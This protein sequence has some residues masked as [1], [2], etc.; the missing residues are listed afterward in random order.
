MRSAQFWLMSTNCV[1][2]GVKCI[3]LLVFSRQSSIGVP[4]PP[5]G[6]FRRCFITDQSCCL[7]SPLYHYLPS[8]CFS[9]S[10][11]PETVL[12]PENGK[13][14]KDQSVPIISDSPLN[15]VITLFQYSII[16]GCCK[17]LV[18]VCWQQITQEEGEVSL[19]EKTL[20]YNEEALR[21]WQN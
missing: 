14:W 21:L 16:I 13:S 2:T 11:L 5:K 3:T 6:Q 12:G 7:Q 15:F 4:S 10:S 19:A 17:P 9:T 1:L 8:Y 20:L 18:S